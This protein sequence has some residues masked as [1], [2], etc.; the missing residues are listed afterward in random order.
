MMPEQFHPGT[1]DRFACQAKAQLRARSMAAQH[2]KPLF[3]R[4]TQNA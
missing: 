4:R 3:I 2:I 1:G